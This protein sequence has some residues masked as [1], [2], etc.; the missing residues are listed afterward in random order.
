[1]LI[2]RSDSITNYVLPVVFTSGYRTYWYY[3]NEALL[4][5]AYNQLKKINGK[6]KAFYP[7]IFD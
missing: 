7:L 2:R 4:F 3:D 1:M 5:K 6:I